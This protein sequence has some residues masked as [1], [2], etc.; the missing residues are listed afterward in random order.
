MTA[1]GSRAGTWTMHGAYLVEMDSLAVLA[2]KR[3]HRPAGLHDPTA[4]DDRRRLFVFG[5]VRSNRPV[6]LFHARRHFV[7]ASG[8]DV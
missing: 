7:H 2:E 5:R 6:F 1:G 4:V 3:E 8:K